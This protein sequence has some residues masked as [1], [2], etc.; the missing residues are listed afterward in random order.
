M[1]NFF[2]LCIDEM[3]KNRLEERERRVE[4][5]LRYLVPEKSR[6][7]GY[8]TISDAMKYFKK[9]P[10]ERCIFKQKDGAEREAIRFR[11]GH[12]LYW[13]DFDGDW[14]LIERYS[15]WRSGKLEEWQ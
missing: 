5:I 4:F 13:L 11:R 14:G 1:N 3:M 9:H 6:L 12:K 10:I 7:I 15:N 2:D 8:V